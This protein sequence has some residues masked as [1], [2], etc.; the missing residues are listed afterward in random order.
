MDSLLQ[1]KILD[2]VESA[3]EREVDFIAALTAHPT[4]RGNEQSAQ[5][6]VARALSDR[7]Y[8]IDRWQINVEDIAHLPGFSPVLGEYEDAVNVVGTHRSRTGSGRSLILNGHI[9]VVPTGPLEM[10]GP[11]AI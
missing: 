2:T 1:R 6:E 5:D 7:G 9:D 8:S 10:W 11:A 4:T 3:F